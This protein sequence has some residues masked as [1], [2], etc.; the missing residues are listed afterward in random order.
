MNQLTRACVLA[1]AGLI[2]AASAATAEEGGN[3]LPGEFSGNVAFYSDYSFRGVSQTS[4]NMALQGGIDWSH[5]T[6]IYLGLWASNVDFSDADIEQDVYGGSSGSIDEVSSEIGAVFLYYPQEEELNYWEFPLN[7]GYD[8]DMFSVS[9][10][11]LFSPEYFGILDEG[12][13]VSGGV[14]VPLPLDLAGLELALDAG[15]GYSHAEAGTVSGEKVYLAGG[16]D[17]D[18]VDWQVGLTIGFP[19]G[20]GIDLRGVGTDAGGDNEL[21]DIADPRFVAGLSY[22]F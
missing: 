8:F 7:L 4:E 17:E 13:V 20:I 11:V 19:S 22:S 16:T 1:S 6:G 10:G 5:D 2:A 12:V 14:E 18:Y 9:A 15:L 21:G 3:L